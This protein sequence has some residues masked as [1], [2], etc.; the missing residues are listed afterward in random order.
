MAVE[1]VTP[2]TAT[3]ETVSTP[4][5]VTDEMESFKQT[6]TEEEMYIDDVEISEEISPN[7]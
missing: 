3:A 5:G 6:D 4:A 7:L 1:F 2:L